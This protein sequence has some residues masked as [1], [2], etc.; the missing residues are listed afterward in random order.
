MEVNVNRSEVAEDLGTSEGRLRYMEGA[1]ILPTFG[2]V[3]E[4]IYRCRA[5][6]VLVARAGGV[7]A[8]SVRIAFAPE[9]VLQ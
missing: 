7:S 2:T 9:A 4:S 5:R 6:V 1:G 3:P 8:A